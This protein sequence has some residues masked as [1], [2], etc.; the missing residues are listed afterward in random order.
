ML[1]LR[2]LIVRRDAE[3]TLVTHEREDDELRL[4]SRQLVQLRLHTGGLHLNPRFAIRTHILQSKLLTTYH[5]PFFVLSLLGLFSYL[6]PLTSYLLVRASCVI[7]HTL[8]SHPL[9]LTY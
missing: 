6:L 4:P 1:R 9:S 7:L 8:T 5:L 2:S 3:A